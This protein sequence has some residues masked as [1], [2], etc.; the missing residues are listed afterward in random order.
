MKNM[1]MTMKGTK[2]GSNL[3]LEFLSYRVVH[4]DGERRA[5]CWI[6]NSNA[7]QMLASFKRFHFRLLA[8]L[9]LK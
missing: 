8:H 5:A 6:L 9:T 2:L 1:K 7:D 4:D 3:V